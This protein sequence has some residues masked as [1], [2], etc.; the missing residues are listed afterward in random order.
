MP[1]SASCKLS[2]CISTF[3]RA[4]FIGATLESI[5]AQATNECE[6]VV[7][8]GA[9]TDNTE[10]VV[11][12]YVAGFKRLRYV[13]QHTNNGIDRDYDRAVELAHGEYCWLMADDDILKPGA[14]VA[15]L[16]ALERDYSLVLVN[17]EWMDLGMTTVLERSFFDFDSDRVYGPGEMDRLFIDTG[18]IL[19]FIG[20]VVIK[21]AIWLQRNRQRYY[22]SL[23]IHVG[24][25]FQERL[26]GETLVT[27]RP[28]VSYRAGNAHTFVPQAFEISVF[29]W[30]SVV[31]SSALSESAK[32]EICS[33]EPWRS[34]HLLLK[35]R[36]LGFY[37]HAEY[38]R[39]IRPRLRSKRE[40]LIPRVVS[41]IPG[42]LV[43]TSFVLYYSMFGRHRGLWLQIL[44]ESR[45]HVR[46]RIRGRR[47]TDLT[48][49]AVEGKELES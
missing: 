17:I 22:G 29:K 35:C 11:L 9:S 30:P 7:L 4:A 36:A 46:N 6:I 41:L 15:M 39:W 28:L 2:I 31:W 12:Q 10:H 34:F 23:F 27:A 18:D 20:C 44:K 38:Q 49:K 40:S 26:P 32:R 37:S 5:I 8:D 3:N 45:F 33:A 14:V 16:K 1:Q 43:N 24:V 13:R 19:R 21:R 47:S 42:V 48:E 25:I